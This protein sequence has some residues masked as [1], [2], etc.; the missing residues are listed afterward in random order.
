MLLAWQ[1]LGWTVI[2]TK[3]RA[4]GSWLKRLVPHRR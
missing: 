1:L 4:V 2:L 3:R